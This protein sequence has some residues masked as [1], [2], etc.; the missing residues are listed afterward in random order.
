MNQSECF[1]VRGML[2]L[3]VG[4]DL[5]SDDTAR[6]G[7][8]LGDCGAC[9]VHL[10]RAQVARHELRSELSRLV[11]GHEPQLWPVL[12]ESLAREGLF[13]AEP[14]TPS[15]PARR[16]AG[17]LSV[18]TWRPVAAV[19]AALL[20]VAYFGQSDPNPTPVR[21]NQP[22]AETILDKGSL[23]Q[24]SAPSTLG[25]IQPGAL[26]ETD[27]APAEASSLSGLRPLG[28]GERPLFDQAR[29]EILKDA[30]RQMPMYQVMPAG[31]PLPEQGELASRLSLQ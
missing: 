29:E 18:R 12:R 16:A 31:Q 20:A 10:T 30:M 6:V 9:Q 2:P 28:L 19:A 1:E 23:I 3:F 24:E 27:T 22:V 21:G 15:A 5:E 7:L 25:T 26:A 17:L 14:V 4:G 11:D 13:R 8:H